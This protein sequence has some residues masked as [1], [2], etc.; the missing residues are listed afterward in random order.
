MLEKLN[1]AQQKAVTHDHSPLLILA[2]AGSGK[3]RVIA[4]RL[5]YL[6]EHDNIPSRSILAVTFTNKAASEMRERIE[7]L[8]GSEAELHVRTFHSFGAWFL[9]RNAQF[10]GLDANFAIYDQDDSIR[11]LKR[12][13]PSFTR[14]SL[15]FYSGWISR[16]K[17]EALGINDNL[18][19]ITPD[20]DFQRVYASY[21]EAKRKSGAADFADLLYLPYKILS[22]EKE[23]RERYHQRFKAVLVDEYQDAN[24]IQWKLLSLLCG[25]ETALCV[26]GDDDQS[27]YRFRGAHVENILNFEKEFNGVTKIKLEENYRSTKAILSVATTLIKGNPD[28]FDKTMF[29]S[30]DEG[31]KP[32]LYILA[33]DNEEA[34]LV[35]QWAKEQPA[36]ETCAILYR[37]NAQSRLFETALK[38]VDVP[39]NIVGAVNFFARQEV[40]DALAYL[41]FAFNPFNLVAFTRSVGQPS[42]G[43]GPST[44]KKIIDSTQGLSISILE[45]AQSMIPQ[46]KGKARLGL[47]QYVELISGVQ[48]LVAEKK[49]LS[50]VLMF[51]ITSSGLLARY[52]EEDKINGTFKE[53]NLE[54]LVASGEGFEGGPEGLSV[55]LDRV[56][57]SSDKDEEESSNLTLITIHGTKGLEYDHVFIVGMENYLFPGSPDA[58]SQEIEEE[59]RL[60]Y[61]AITRARKTLALSTTRSRFYHGSRQYREPSMFLSEIPGELLKSYISPSLAQKSQQMGAEG[62]LPRHYVPSGVEGRKIYH[63]EY[64]YGV[65]L[66]VTK[67]GDYTKVQAQFGSGKTAVFI[68]EFSKNKVEWLS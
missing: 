25:P 41:Q 26:V 66:A 6:V 13:E 5:A 43:I 1:P 21:E 8:L 11:L 64:G 9:R 19:S 49:A 29:T 48:S 50:D 34:Q 14:E 38:R 57:L 32:G 59:R 68:A 40:K 56:V 67:Q 47:Q 12:V 4:N 58:P 18:Q 55:Y 20:P 63:Q 45:T 62:A 27:I 30:N 24:T 2:G 3:T 33:D 16:A 10:A 36:D 39:Y 61:V 28:R 44:Q 7:A 60:L 51:I 46:L 22:S 65:V 42:R 31:Q 35:S 37:T 52:K 53:A 23:V 15:K 54:E 17:E